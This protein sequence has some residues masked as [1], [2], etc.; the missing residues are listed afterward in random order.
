MSVWFSSTF[1][2]FCCFLLAIFSG[3]P[4]VAEHPLPVTTELYT[5]AI[6]AVIAIE[7]TFMEVQQ[8]TSDRVKENLPPVPNPFSQQQNEEYERGQELVIPPVSRMEID[9]RR[10]AD[11]WLLLQESQRLSA[12][13]TMKANMEEAAKY[14][15]PTPQQQAVYDDAIM[16]SQAV[17]GLNQRPPGVGLQ[18]PLNAIAVFL[19]ISEDVSPN[20][21]YKVPQNAEVEIV[22]FS[23]QARIIR[24]L[25]SGV[26]PTGKYSITWDGL[27]NGGEPAESG[28]YV[29][30]VRIGNATFFRKRIVVP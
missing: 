29:A 21:S 7:S 2:S 23:P 11:L 27:T 13:S 20:I 26:Q 12:T 28:D 15:T 4:I 19:G 18:M 25:F 3:L 8:D 16:R 30:E 14:F 17:P 1:A 10:T 6:S 5:S 24:N 22:V 9:L